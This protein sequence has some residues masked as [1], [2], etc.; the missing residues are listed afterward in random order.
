MGA[1]SSTLDIQT[2]ER[3]SLEVLAELS[4][5]AGSKSN[6][7]VFT[8]MAAGKGWVTTSELKNYMRV[9]DSPLVLNFNAIKSLWFTPAH[10][11]RGRSLVEIKDTAVALR[12]IV[13]GLFAKFAVD[14]TAGMSVTEFKSFVEASSCGIDDSVIDSSFYECT[15]Y[16]EDEDNADEVSA[17]RADTGKFLSSVIRIANACELEAT[18]E[19]DKGLSQQLLDWLALWSEPL[20]IPEGAIAAIPREAQLL[21]EESFFG[22]PV[23]F[24]TRDPPPRVFMDITVDGEPAWGGRVVF[25][26]NNAVAPKTAYNFLCLCTGQ[27][28]AGE[29]TGVPLSYRGCSFHRVV[30]GMCVQGGDLQGANGYGGESIYG[31][32]FDDE[33]FTLQH[34]A[35]GVLSMGNTGQNTNTSQFFIT[36]AAAPHLDLESC[37]FGTVVE[38]MDVVRRMGAVAVNEDDVPLK[39]WTIIGCGALS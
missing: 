27:R 16:P 37:A 6:E 14:G 19:S 7:T 34:N 33:C 39:A 32:E 29:V 11:G 25:E 4:S 9:V 2:E 26:L 5:S 17:I 8:V 36:L 1:A 38:G 31:G 10:G 30:A 18:G 28:G 21:R 23:D 12:E 13:T 22:P 35:E 15:S 3:L 20:H 24:G